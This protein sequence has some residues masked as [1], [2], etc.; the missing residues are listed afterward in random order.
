MKLFRQTLAILGVVLVIQLAQ[1]GAKATTPA[2]PELDEILGEAGFVGIV[3]CEEAGCVV[4]TT[5][6]ANA[7]DYHVAL[8]PGSKLFL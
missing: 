1:H 5:G 7:H 3:E 8:H 4:A 6:I 2:P